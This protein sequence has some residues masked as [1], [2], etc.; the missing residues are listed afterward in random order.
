V[1][2]LLLVA[3]LIGTFLWARSTY[4]RIEKIDLTDVLDP[5]TGDA[6]NYLLVGS[7]SRSEFDPEGES[8]VEG[9]R[10]DTII[11]LRIT[12]EGAAMMSIPRDLWVEVADTGEMGRINGAYNRGPANLVRTV[13]NNLDVPVNHYMEVGF[14]SFVGLVDA[15]GGV[16]IN[17]PNPVFDPGSGL[18]VTTAGDVTLDGQQ[19]LAYARARN[20]TEVING[21]E[22]KEPTAD[23]GRQQRQ[24]NFLRTAMREVGATRNPVT[25]VRVADAMSSELIVDSGLGFW[26]ATTMVRKLGGSDPLTVVLPTEGARR[27]Q[28]A[29]L[30]LDQPAA[31]QV[32]AAFR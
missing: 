13:Q 6:T 30:V 14:G 4:S 16:T 23:L 25:L 19:A 18:N 11:L 22:V 21:E 29:V 10:S 9:T 3:A 17:F 12:P 24:Q 27:G 15:I 2:P 5:V 28:A 20:Y 26:E 1:I 8:G 31:E 32:L 7:D